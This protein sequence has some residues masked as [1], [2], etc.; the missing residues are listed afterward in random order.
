MAAVAVGT[1]FGPGRGAETLGPMIEAEPGLHPAAMAKALPR[2]LA[3]TAAAALVVAI[4]APASLAAHETKPPAGDAEPPPSVDQLLQ[5]FDTIVFQS[6]F[7]D[8]APSKVIKKWTQP[9]RVA[10]R[11]FAETIV[12]KDGHELRQLQQV[13]LKKPYRKFIRKHLG[14]LIAATGLKTEDARKTGKD[15][16]FTINFVPRSQTANPYFANTERQLLKRLA[17]EGG[18]FFLVWADAETGNIS[19]AVI[20]VNAE[21]LLIRINHCLLE[22]MT[23]SL[24]LPNDTNLLS[25][26]I[27]SDASRRTDLSRTDLIVL[28]TLYDPRMQAGLPRARALEIARVI[29]GELNARLP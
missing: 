8:L 20:V 6:E 21:R 10:I 15:P 3:R 1:P 17:A 26:S 7:K 13:K 2:A 23:Q 11:A 5:H 22:E 29:I 18:C 9:L 12:D 27:F 14:S 24:G 16:N 19:K 25:P 4:V 28:K